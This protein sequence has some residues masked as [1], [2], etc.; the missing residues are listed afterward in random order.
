MIIPLKTIIITIYNPIIFMPYYTILYH[1]IYIYMYIQWQ[2]QEPKLEVPTMY[3]AYVRAMEGNITT[4]YGLIWYSTSILGSWNSHWII[5][6]S[7]TIIHSFDRRG[8]HGLELLFDHWPRWRRRRGATS[9]WP[10]DPRFWRRVKRREPG[11]WSEAMGKPWENHGKRK[12]ME[13]SWRNRGEIMEK[14]CFEIYVIWRYV[15][16]IYWRLVFF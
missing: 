15:K 8:S 7:I 9:Q 16:F 6:V 13:K 11:E 5:P 1:H 12:I 4:K 3:K 10:R 14:L 2:F